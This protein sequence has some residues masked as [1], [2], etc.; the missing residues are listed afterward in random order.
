MI[1]IVRPVGLFKKTAKLSLRSTL[2]TL[3]ETTKY[4]TTGS[5]R[6]P[7]ELVNTTG[8]FLRSKILGKLDVHPVH[9]TT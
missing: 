7:P 9:L 4:L 3:I 1:L 6:M 5:P 2:S 8:E